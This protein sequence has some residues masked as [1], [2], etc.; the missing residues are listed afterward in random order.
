MKKI[1]GLFLLTIISCSTA[2]KNIY[3][4]QYSLDFNTEQTK[5]LGESIIKYHKGYFKKA[6]VFNKDIVVNSKNKTY[7]IQKG[8]TFYHWAN[9][10]AYQDFIPT[11]TTFSNN[12][13]FFD[14]EVCFDTKR[15]E[16]L[17]GIKEG[18]SFSYLKIE[19][20][21]DVSETVYPNKS[22]DSRTL[23]FIYNGTSGNTAKFT[24]REYSNDYARPEFTQETQYDLNESKII[25]FKGLRIEIIKA[26]NTLITYKILNGFNE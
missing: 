14:K 6:I 12:M 8:E 11:Y 18:L 2:S 25:G 7:H 21:P 26:T 1:L 3:H 20:N 24:Y 9:T 5:E 4:Q 16:F 13:A 17:L 23:E 15:N 19:P 10:G 22:A